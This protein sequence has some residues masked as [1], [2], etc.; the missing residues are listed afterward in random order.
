MKQ[1]LIFFFGEKCERNRWLQGF[2]WFA[3]VF[4]FVMLAC[5]LYGLLLTGRV[6]LL[7]PVFLFPFLFQ[8]VYAQFRPTVGKEKRR[9]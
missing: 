6:L 8:V 2:Y 5:A 9:Y 7:V 4:F 3:V 1:L